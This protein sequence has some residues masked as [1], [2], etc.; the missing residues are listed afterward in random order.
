MK[1]YDAGIEDLEPSLWETN[2]PQALR[3]TFEKFSNK[4]ALE[5]MGVELTFGELDIYS[6]K[7]AHFLLNVGLHK[8][9]VIGLNLAN[10]PQFVIALLGAMKIGCVV[11]GV[12]PLLSEEQLSY[13]L[14]DS[15]A[16][17][18]ITLDAVFE[19]KL[20]RIAT[21]LKFLQ[22]IVTTNVGDFL[23][24]YK[25]ILG[26][27]TKKIPTG[28]VTPLNGIIIKDFF[29]VLRAKEYSTLLPS[30]NISPDDL[31]FIIYTGG[32]TGPPK[33]AMLSHRNIMA[34]LIMVHKWL[35]WEQGKGL[36]LSGFP[37]FHVAGLFF[38]ENCLYLGW[39]QLLV[40]NPRDTNL[41]CNLIA[42]YKP[43]ALVNVPSLYQML[44]ANPKF[45]TLDHSNLDT[46]ISSASP[47]PVESQKE[48]EAIVGKGKL[49]E[50]YGM[51]ETSPLT[52]MN[53]YRGVK[54]LGTIGLP[55]MNTDIKLVDPGTQ[56][57][58]KI[59]EPGEMLIKGPQVMKGYWKKPEETS[60]TIDEE[61][62]LHSG[63]V[64]V[65]DEEG[66]LRLVDRTK[67][68]IIV[69]GFKVFSNKL[70]NILSEHPAIHMAATIGVP[71][72]ERPGSEFVKTYLTI[73]PDYQ[74]DKE[75]PEML[76]QE[77]TDWIR[78]KV[79]P[80]EVPKFIE[81]REELPLTLVGKVD[82]RLLRNEK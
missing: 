13:Q 66:Y 60:N 21:D 25:Q 46:C 36:A 62:W 63:D 57:V 34:D 44:L 40:P 37:F 17:A 54:K 65:F 52:V 50:V 75:K 67:D 4:L 14:N 23:P 11:T 68:M 78:T 51:T 59:G 41:I 58:V 42:K 26:K 29:D 28:K 16:K 1:S 5:Y 31:A 73:S 10:M 76:K 77:I 69:G 82:K 80:Y 30:N 48:L 32:T 43:T 35:N 53:P 49:L 70:E 55:L 24:K 64:A 20:T 22:L 8:G 6:N 33:G 38:C 12:S 71:N 15:E 27:L 9:D 61:G 7:F 19:R 45:K 18:I 2:F 79:A 72:P 39:S 81:I 3:N 47:F 74:Y 56:E